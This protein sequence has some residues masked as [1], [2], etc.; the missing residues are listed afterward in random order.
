[1]PSVSAHGVCPSRRIC[2]Q[3]LSVTS[4]A[5]SHL[6]QRPWMAPVFE[7]P[8]TEKVACQP[9]IR[10]TSNQVQRTSQ[11]DDPW[12]DRHRHGCDHMVSG[13]SSA[14]PES[15]SQ[16]C[17]STLEIGSR[18]STSLAGKLRE[19]PTLTTRFVEVITLQPLRKSQS[20]RRPF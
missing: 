9:I 2:R 18:V 7:P 17:A 11:E 10:D 5:S 4:L 13:R 15:V 12:G 20:Q 8:A 19:R 6:R 1:M 3:S 14:P 16:T